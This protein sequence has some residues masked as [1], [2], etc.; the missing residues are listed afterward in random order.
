MA[1]S[2]ADFSLL[3]Y[4]TY[5]GYNQGILTQFL[6]SQ[7]SWNYHSIKVGGFN[8]TDG[9]IGIYLTMVFTGIVQ[10]IVTDNDNFGAGFLHPQPAVMELRFIDA[11][12]QQNR[13]L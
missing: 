5:K 12:L 2:S 6:R 7:T 1:D 8:L 10:L 13:N 3:V 9:D 11:A 4:L